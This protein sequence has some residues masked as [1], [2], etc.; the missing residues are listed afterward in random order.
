M[1]KILSSGKH[2][3]HRTQ[4]PS[5]F[6]NYCSGVTKYGYEVQKS[7]NGNSFEG[8]KIKIRNIFLLFTF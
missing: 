3:V 5:E 4:S 8:E 2:F 6:T 1:Y 7:I